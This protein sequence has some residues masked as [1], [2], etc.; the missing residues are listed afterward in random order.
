MAIVS[1]TTIYAA[2]FSTYYSRAVAIVREQRLHATYSAHAQDRASVTRAAVLR[3]KDS[4]SITHMRG[5]RNPRPLSTC[6]RARS[7][8]FA[9]RSRPAARSAVDV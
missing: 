1:P 3:R 2:D 9:P 6:R 8:S 7:R 5:K 4:D